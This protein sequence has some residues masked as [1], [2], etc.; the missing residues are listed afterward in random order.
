MHSRLN[1]FVNVISLTLSNM[2]D[3]PTISFTGDIYRDSQ[4]L[5]IHHGRQ[6]T[7]EHSLRVAA[8][9]KRLALRWN[10]DPAKAEIAG[11]LHDISAIIPRNLQLELAESQHIDVLP[12]E[13]THPLLLHQKLSAVIAGEI[14][15]VLDQLILDAIE[16]H[17]TLKANSSSLDKIVFIADK[18]K[19]DQAGDPPYLEAL[20]AALKQSLDA[21]AFLYL[22]YLWQQRET[23][24]AL[25][26]WVA[27]AT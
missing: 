8:E 21:G 26:P 4:A 13:R 11:W 17:T 27:E 19:W 14:F 3:N 15:L 18:L 5:L 22:N 10:E 6:A 23:L 12:E 2:F 24:L 1:A 25:H 9:A 20:Q 7:A 16:C